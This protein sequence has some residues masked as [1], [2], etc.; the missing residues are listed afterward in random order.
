MKNYSKILRARLKKVKWNE[1]LISDHYEESLEIMVV[2]FCEML[3]E[4]NALSK[5]KG[6]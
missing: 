5:G 3:D 6:K 4:I 2:T 1:R